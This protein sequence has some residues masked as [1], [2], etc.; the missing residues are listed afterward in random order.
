MCTCA[1]DAAGDHELAGDVELLAPGEAAA[2]GDDALAL[3]RHVPG[4][5]DPRAHDAA[6]LQYEVMRH[7]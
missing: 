2:E 6:V 5:V 4:E 7:A 3:D 1:V